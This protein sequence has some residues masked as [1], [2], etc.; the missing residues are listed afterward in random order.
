M[1][2]SARVVFAIAHS[3]W[4]AR[5]YR[6][7]CKNCTVQPAQILVYINRVCFLEIDFNDG[8]LHFGNNIEKQNSYYCDLN[9]NCEGP[10][11]LC[12]R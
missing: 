12:F 8:N 4:C 10:W 11:P 7:N 3:C 5:A 9:N 1:S 6:G 2:A